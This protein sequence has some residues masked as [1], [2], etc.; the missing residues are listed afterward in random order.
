M[1]RAWAWRAV[2]CVT[3]TWAAED[4]KGEEDANWCECGWWRAWTCLETRRSRPLSHSWHHESRLQLGIHEHIP[5]D[6]HGLAFDHSPDH[7]YKGEHLGLQ[8]TLALHHVSS[9]SSSSLQVL[10]RKSE[11]KS[12]TRGRGKGAENQTTKHFL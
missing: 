7:L 9:T 6:H 5:D 12:A 3:C 11:K 4:E 2:Q 10:E 8:P 1:Y